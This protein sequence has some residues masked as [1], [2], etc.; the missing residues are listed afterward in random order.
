VAGALVDAV[1]W[2]RLLVAAG[3][4]MIATAASALALHPTFLFVAFAE[5]LHGLTAGL[6]TPAIAAISLGLV[7]RRAMSCRIGRNYG[8]SAAGNA[9]TAAA[10]GALGS[11]V[12]R[13]SIFLAAAGL[14]VPALV[15]L[16][17][18]R[19]EE[20]D[21]DRARNAGRDQD[22]RTT[23][24]GLSILFE[25]RQLLWFALSAALFQLADASM[26]TLAVEDIGRAGS[27]E[28]SGMTAA[29]IVA[30]QIVVALLAPW[31]GYFSEL[32]GRR[33]LLLASFAVQIVRAVLFM[34][35][36]D[37][38]VLIAVQT[39]DGISGAARTVLITVIVTDLTTGTGRFNLARGAIGLVATI[40]A[41]ISTTA[42]GFIAQEMG[43]WAAFSGMA[44]MAAAGAMVFWFRVAETKPAE[45]V[46]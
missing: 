46:D 12:G 3:I 9:L 27:T 10:M 19:K 32:W 18:V 6:I 7:G 28:S 22:G 2:K 8:F 45:Y 13:S 26:L 24:Q 38:L 37:P 31:V 44:A 30:P 34:L 15:A 4:V 17:F 43:H 5:V 20:I 14:T 16:G 39:L 1:R 35:V 42:F 29:L 23:L 33:P 36:A 21:H 41:A 25:N 40:A 11:Y